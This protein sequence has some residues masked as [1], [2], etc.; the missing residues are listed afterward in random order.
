M[1]NR[2]KSGGN[3]L[4]KVKTSNKGGKKLEQQESRLRKEKPSLHQTGESQTEL[5]VEKNA[6][7]WVPGGGNPGKRESS[8]HE[9]ETKKGEKHDQGHDETCC[10]YRLKAKQKKKEHGEGK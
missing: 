2:Q 3:Q 6:F 8:R 5:Q 7:D 1:L 9:G 4:R 10:I